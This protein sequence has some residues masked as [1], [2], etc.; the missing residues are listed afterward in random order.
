MKPGHLDPEDKGCTE[1]EDNIKV[2]IVSFLMQYI[3]AFSEDKV[4]DG[5][6]YPWHSKQTVVNQVVILVQLLITT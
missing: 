2:W 6:L 4:A 5:S 3:F 1:Y